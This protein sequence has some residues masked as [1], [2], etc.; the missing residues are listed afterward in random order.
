MLYRFLISKPNRK[1]HSEERLAMQGANRNSTVST[2]GSKR[3]NIEWLMARLV[4]LTYDKLRKKCGCLN[5]LQ[6]LVNLNQCNP[7]RCLTL[8]E[9][10]QWLMLFC[11]PRTGL[12]LVNGGSYFV[13]VGSHESSMVRQRGWYS[14]YQ[15]QRNWRGSGLQIISG[16]ASDTKDQILLVT[17]ASHIWRLNLNL[18][19]PKNKSC[20]L[21]YAETLTS[22]LL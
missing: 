12:H 7:G 10:A 11:L 5:Q 13:E 6:T 15:N 4:L 20:V 21:A 22:C 2:R 1:S 17:K 9:I 18:K 19:T 14:L 16:R 8:D 3:W